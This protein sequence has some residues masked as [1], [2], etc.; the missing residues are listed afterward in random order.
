M[1]SK[2]IILI[3]L[4]GWMPTIVTA[5]QNI[6][7]DLKTLIQKSIAYFPKL[8]ETELGLQA[9]KEKL[10]I[11]KSAYYP[12]IMLNAGYNYIDRI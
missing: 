1:L 9:G 7:S 4:A 8:K 6:N 10:E 11:A 12:N 3:V 2:K 5:Q